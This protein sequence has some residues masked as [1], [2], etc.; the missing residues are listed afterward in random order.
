MVK[1]Y[2]AKLYPKTFDTWERV[3]PDEYAKV[4]LKADQLR[5]WDED[6]FDITSTAGV[7]TFAAAC[8]SCA[9]GYLVLAATF[10]FPYGY[11]IYVGLDAVVVLSPL[12]FTGVREYLRKDKLIIKI[13]LLES[14]MKLL[15]APSDVQ[16]FPMLALAK[17]GSP[18]S[19]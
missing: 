10:G 19:V 7:L 12:W 9:G 17:T 2:D 18:A 5:Q 1:G 16:V 13:N 4:K 11:W 6:M 3:T 14:V 15:T 8:V